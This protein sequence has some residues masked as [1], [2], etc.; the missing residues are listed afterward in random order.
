MRTLTEREIDRRWPVTTTIDS[1]HVEAARRCIALSCGL[2]GFSDWVMIVRVNTSR[3]S[4]HL[5][6]DLKHDD[7][8]P[9][10][11]DSLVEFRSYLISQHACA[12]AVRLAGPVWKRYRRWVERSAESEARHE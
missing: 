10:G 2:R 12:I 8:L 3:L 11:F 9:E 6:L 7:T 1:S 5:L 4:D